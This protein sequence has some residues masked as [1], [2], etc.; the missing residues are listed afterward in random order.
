[1]KL[2]HLDFALL[3]LLVS[4]NLVGTLIGVIYYM[5]QLL[6]TSP[7]LWVFV[8]D[9]PLYTGL[10][11]FLILLAIA[12]VKSDLFGFL[13][14]VG[15][16]KYGAW[17][18]FVL[19]F[20]SN[21]FFSFATYIWLQSTILFI[22]HIGMMLEGFI[23]PFKKVTALQMVVVL[24]WFFINDF[25]DYFGPSVHPYLPQGNPLPATAFALLSTFAFTLLA[26]GFAKNNYRIHIRGLS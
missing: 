22:L 11:A 17:T 8:P 1:M 12:G 10:F 16:M 3:S 18:L 15:L 23:L 26:A 20:Y 4:A 21:Y 13:V 19:A 6:S 2:S 5:S 14:S 24:A 9:C 25:L 7:L